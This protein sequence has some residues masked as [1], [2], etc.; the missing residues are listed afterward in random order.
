[1]PSARSTSC[2]TLSTCFDSEHKRTSASTS[3][4]HSPAHSLANTAAHSPRAD[5]SHSLA[6]H[7]LS[8]PTAT[9]APTSVF[10]PALWPSLSSPPLSLHPCTPPAPSNTSP[11]PFLPLPC[12]RH[13][14]GQG[15]TSTI[16]SNALSH[17]SPSES[18]H[19]D[20]PPLTSSPSSPA[21][22]IPTAP[23]LSASP[24]DKWLVGGRVP[25]LRVG[26]TVLLLRL[27]GGS[28]PVLS[29]PSCGLAQGCSM[30]SCALPQ[31]CVCI[32]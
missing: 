4:A 30:S 13:S 21:L 20:P 14:C 27:L 32:E 15:S 6:P 24:P 29:T 3:A 9:L 10:A 31:A 16:H 26:G 7:S 2:R 11:A 25:L 8:Q 22:A 23:L 28:V 19:V 18:P 12:A 5:S 1:M 17:M